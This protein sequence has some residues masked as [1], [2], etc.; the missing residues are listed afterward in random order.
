MDFRKVLDSN[1]NYFQGKNSGFSC[2]VVGRITYRVL[3][4]FSADLNIMCK[5]W[6]IGWEIEP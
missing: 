2:R 3:F 5:V 6:V 4:E 1:G